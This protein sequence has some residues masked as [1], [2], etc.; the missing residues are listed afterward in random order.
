MQHRTAWYSRSVGL[1]L[2]L[3][4]LF[5]MTLSCVEATPSPGKRIV[6]NIPAR[7]LWL[8]AGED[9]VKA[10]S[11]GVGK[12]EFPTPLG[13]YRVIHKV[14]NPVFEDPFRGPRLFKKRSQGMGALGTRWIGFLEANG[15][16]YGI[17]GTNQPSSVGQYSS[18]GCIRMTVADAEDL[19]DRVDFGTPVE[20][21]YEPVVMMIT[22]D[23]VKVTVF[24][25]T[26]GKGMPGAGNIRQRM[27][28][29]LK[30]AKI[31]ET[32]LSQALKSP[33]EEPV[34]V[35]HIAGEPPPEQNEPMVD[36]RLRISN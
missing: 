8:M 36:F 32:A 16:E 12:P 22:E 1:G 29:Y 6:V 23:Q 15:G 31:D 25:D 26:W 19:F 35:G 9:V 4:L 28:T 20:V 17:H 2:I 13:R 18:H 21:I 5:F 3:F 14:Q 33:T 27:E 11:V 34:T 30:G 7:T 24:P 10:Y